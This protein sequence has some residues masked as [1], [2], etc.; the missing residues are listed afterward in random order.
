MGEIELAALDHVDDA[1]GC[2][3]HHVDPSFQGTKLQA[4]G[5]ASINGNRPRMAAMP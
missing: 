4:D 5:L 3:H 1:A 2:S